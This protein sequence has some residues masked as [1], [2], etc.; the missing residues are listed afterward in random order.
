[1]R[2]SGNEEGETG[3][4]EEHSWGTGKMKDAGGVQQE[5]DDAGDAKQE[6]RDGRGEA[7]EA[8]GCGTKGAHGD[9]SAIRWHSSQ[10]GFH[11][12]AQGKSSISPGRGQQ[13]L[14]NGT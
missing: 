10:N 8:E 2:Q 7:A 3:K 14:G 4:E 13:V 12:L 1:M 6:R 5:R 9:D 11:P